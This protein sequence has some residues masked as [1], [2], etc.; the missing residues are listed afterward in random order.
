[1]NILIVKTQM[2]IKNVNI[3]SFCILFFL[4]FISTSL[5]AGG[6]SC[7]GSTDVVQI[8]VKH[9]NNSPPTYAYIVKNLHKSPIAIVAIS[10]G[11]S[12]HEEMYSIQDNVP[13]TFVSPEDWEGGTA[14]T[15]ESVVM[16]IY[17]KTNKTALLAP[18]QSLGGFKV[19]MP[20]PVKK[21]GETYNL[22]GTLVK[23]LDMKK[24]PFNVFF[25]DGRCVWGRVKE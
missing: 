9:E 15:D 21:K 17:W 11:D 23:A 19:E 10:L 12:D 20:Q 5:W 16:R 2:K 18:G 14:F 24:A 1:M 6:V 3:V 25:E 22:Y 4:Y 13:K 7:D 8:T